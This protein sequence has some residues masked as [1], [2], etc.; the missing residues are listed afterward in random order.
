MKNIRIWVCNLV[1]EWP[2]PT[3]IWRQV[4]FSPVIFDN[5]LKIVNQGC[6]NRGGQGGL[7]APQI[8][9]EELT[10]TQIVGQIMPTTLLLAPL[11]FQTFLRAFENC[12]CRGSQVFSGTWPQKLT[13]HLPK[14][15]YN[16]KKG[17]NPKITPGMFWN[18]RSNTEDN[19]VH[20]M[21]FMI[22][23]INSSHK[24]WDFAYNFC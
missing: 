18:I 13:Q 14:R 16:H 8:L 9:T 20:I 22:S 23:M 3:S 10:L 19:L 21:Y 5:E 17:Q 6:R 24:E 1:N 12:Q 7:I 15:Q 4:Q 11:D 2:W